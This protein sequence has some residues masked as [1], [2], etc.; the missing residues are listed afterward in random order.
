MLAAMK[1]FVLGSWIG[2]V[3]VL[4]GCTEDQLGNACGTGFDAASGTVGDFGA[5]DAAQKVEALL[6]A[7]ADL[8]TASVEVEADV[9]G[10]CTA[11]A[12]DLGVPASEL[13]PGANELAVTSACNRAITEID[14]IIA[15]LPAGVA[16]GISITPASCRVD[17]DLAATCAAECDV[18]I[19]GQAMV[20]CT[21]ELHGSCSGS[22][23]GSC[24][25][26]GNVAC[27]GAC[28]GSCTGTC[29]GTC[30][31]TCSGT[32]SAT[33][34]Q[35]NCA[36]S[37]SGTCTGTCS[38]TCSGTCSGTCTASVTGSC[39]G[40]CS[41]SCDATWDAEC[42][43]EANVTANAECKAACDTRA[44]AR[45][46][47]DPPTVTIVGVALADA[48]AAARVNALVQT[49]R[50]NYPRLLRAQS[51]VQLAIAPSLPGFVSALQ[52]ATTSL[53]SVGVQATACMAVA[54]DAVVGSVAQINASVSVTV[55]VSASVSASGS[56]N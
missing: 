41:G 10:A 54:V 26:E 12:T 25:I 31:G 39:T 17:L 19:Q 55:E 7:S 51:R 22:C 20:E 36:G 49:L 13:A 52:A 47:C 40:Q 16:L 37:C 35:G 28:S 45:A 38:A 2:I 50:T 44:N 11:I 29:S 34:A 18:S 8:Y 24:A 21:G 3:A 5:G 42:S 33:D 14:A 43:G 48:Q 15:T 27:T 56:A 23:S 32:C 4:G 53:R 30:H 1:T 46:T 6:H 9:R